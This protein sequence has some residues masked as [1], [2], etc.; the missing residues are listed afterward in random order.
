MSSHFSFILG[1]AKQRSTQV[2]PTILPLVI[3][4][5]K[6]FTLGREPLSPHTSNSKPSA[7]SIPTAWNTLTVLVCTNSIQPQSLIQIPP[8][9]S[10]LDLLFS[11]DLYKIIICTTHSAL[12]LI[13]NV[14]GFVLR[15]WEI[16]HHNIYFPGKFPFVSSNV[17]YHC[18]I[19]TCFMHQGNFSGEIHGL[20]ERSLFQSVSDSHSSRTVT[21]LKY[22]YQKSGKYVCN[23]ELGLGISVYLYD[24]RQTLNQDG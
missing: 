8:L 16:G 1:L 2:R 10:A 24:A 4:K 19:S 21:P 6:F 18:M 17:E 11:T 23:R 22:C 3:P 15:P 12:N 5:H 14:Y 20:S 13:S 9:I 7:Y